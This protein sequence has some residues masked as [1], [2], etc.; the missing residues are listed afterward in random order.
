M[1]NKY[2]LII[3]LFLVSSLNMFAQQAPVLEVVIQE[4]QAVC[5]PGDCIT[6]SVN[7]TSAKSTSDYTV[8]SITYQN[9]Y[10]YLYQPNSGGVRI[11]STADDSWAPLQPL[12]FPFCFYNQTYNELLVGTNGLI[13]FTTNGAYPEGNPEQGSGYILNGPIPNTSSNPPKNAIYGVCQDTDIRLPGTGGQVVDYD[14]QNVNY[15]LGGVAPNRYFVANFNKLPLYNATQCPA[16]YAT[17]NFLQ[18]SQIVIYEGTNIIDVY[19]KKRQSCNSTSVPGGGFNNGLGIIGVQNAAGTAARFPTSPNRNTGPWSTTNEAWRFIPSGTGPESVTFQWTDSAGTILGTGTSINV[20]PTVNETYKVEAIYKKCDNTFYP[21]VSDTYEVIIAPPLPVEDPLDLTLCTTNPP[22]YAFNNFNVDQTTH[23]LD[24]APDYEYDIFY[25]TN[26]TAA[27]NLSTS[28]ALTPTQLANF[29]VPDDTPVTIYA[30]IIETGGNSCHNVRS[31][32]IQGGTPSGTFSYPDDGG[33]PGFCINSNP[34]MAP[35]LN[36]LTTGGTYTIVPATGLIIDPDT[37]VLDLTAATPANYTI[38]YT[39]PEVPGACPEFTTNATVLIEGCISTTPVTPSPVCEGTPT[40]NLTTSDAGPGATYAWTGPNGF[41]SNVKDPTGVPVPTAPGDYT[42]TVVATITG[43]DSAPSSTILTV[44]PIP[45]VAFVSASTTICTNATTI[46]QV[47]GTPGAAVTVNEGTVPHLITLDATTGLGE[48]TTSTLSADTTITIVDVVSNTIPA[49]NFTPSPSPSIV[50]SVGLPTATMTGFTAPV[51]CSGTTGTFTIQGTPGATV[52]YTVNAANPQDVLLPASGTLA[53]ETPIQNVTAVYTYEL[54]NITSAGPDPCSNAITGQSATLTVNAL[55]TASFSTSTPTVCQNTSATINFTGTPGAVVTYSDGTSNGTVTLDGTG[56]FVLT[57]ALLADPSLAY[58]YTLVSVSVTSSGVSCTAPLTGSL[59]ID[60]DADPVFVSISPA[61]G[62]VLCIGDPVTLSVVA[63][64]ANLSY[65]WL[66]DGNPVGTDSATLA[67]PSASIADAGDYTVEISGSCGTPVTS[68]VVELILNQPTVITDQPDG[69]T[70]CVGQPISLEVVA[71]GISLSYQWYKGTTLLAGE[72]SPTL[73]IASAILSDAGT[74]TCRITNPCPQVVTTQDAVVIVN[75]LPAITG[76]IPTPAAICAG[77]PINLTVAATGTALAYQWK[78]NNIDLPGATSA[79][80][81][82]VS[83]TMAEAGDYTVEVSGAC[84]P[85]VT[86][87]IVTIVVNEGATITQQPVALPSDTVCS[88]ES[89]T[90]EVATTGGTNTSY[91]WQKGGINIPGATGATFTINPASVSDTGT[92]TCIISSDS[93][94]SF[95]SDPVAITVNQAPGISGQPQ[96]DTICVGEEHHF[97]ILAT[98]S[99]VTYQ[100]YKD[101]A[102]LPGATSNVYSISSATTADS[103]DY[104]CVVSSASCPDVQSDVATLTVVP[105]PVATI[106]N[107]SVSVICSGESSEVVFQGTPGAMVVYN[108][109]GVSDNETAVLDVLGQAIVAT[110]T[111]VQTTV[112]ELVSV[113]YTGVDA[114]SQA[115]TGSVTV[116]VNELPEVSLEDGY[117]C[118]DPITNAVTRTYVLDTGLNTAQ[119]IFE[120]SDANGVI[121]G[122]S[123]SF[124]EASAVG[125]YGVKITDSVTLCEQSA[126]A[127]VYKSSPPVSFDYT[128]NGFFSQNPTVTITAQPAGDYEYQLDYG[129]FQESNVF[130]NISTGIHTITVRDPQACDVLSSEVTIIDY[131]KYFT[132]NGDGIHDT[133]NI[134]EFGEE[135]NAKIYIFDRF[136]KLVKQISTKGLGWDGTFNGQ[137]MPATDYWFTLDY[138]EKGIRKEFKAHF[139]LKR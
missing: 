132:P 88:G 106:S 111:L 102:A 123:N 105:L 7:Y 70:V 80:Y 97:P 114:C 31:F 107:G 14:V 64:G 79:T 72:T 124:Y 89:I 75:E 28:Q 83:V 63:T 17:E 131:P 37:G 47:Q 78:R 29:Q 52:T 117:I 138:E 85:P 58:T 51:I 137:L 82:D 134:S 67:I 35:V 15:Y 26:E 2:L 43:T 41:L 71:T 104:Y 115:L 103:G 12:D 6:L 87:N 53:V 116:T 39:I 55:P 84:A 22:P 122:A 18:T 4:P 30:L 94:P 36:D 44:Y 129:P 16:N 11:N 27:N 45:T 99:N 119:Y 54:T 48:F 34:A 25:F 59:S 96:T 108:I 60:V 8:Q 127:N 120:W 98:G 113:T 32:T 21:P 101:A 125:Q 19:V 112:Y 66:R 9:L 65:Q 126:F 33:D 10:S 93:C 130:D 128:V 91:Q 1:K 61:T 81:A 68:T 38:T 3:C 110:G 77:E 139:S 136:G 20:C 62:T 92:Y 40:F 90:L 118:V 46:I 56:T 121:A 13:T 133:W 76:T 100:W 95:P 135:L 42:Y 69:Q 57:T 23:I 73:D 74:Y 49:C 24:G 5:N 109:V 86:S 50:I